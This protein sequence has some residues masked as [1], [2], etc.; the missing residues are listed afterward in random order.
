LA[1]KQA[2]FVFKL[3]ADTKVTNFN[4]ALFIDKQILQLDVSVHDQV[5]AAVPQTRRDLDKKVPGM[6]LFE[7]FASP[8]VAQ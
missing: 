4:E 7:L 6:R 5:L 1:T 3:L 2:C 8:N